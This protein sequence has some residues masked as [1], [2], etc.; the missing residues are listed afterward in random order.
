MRTAHTA[1]GLA[2]LLV[3]ASS[4]FAQAPAPAP[5]A[6]QY[7]SRPLR[8][9]VPFPPGGGTDIGTRIIALLNTEIV[10]I[11]NLPDVK[12]RLLSQGVEPIGNT[13]EQFVA[14]LKS[15]IAK[16]GKLMRESGVKAE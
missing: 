10:R 5:A 9:I 14:V 11:L 13:Q 15:D 8:F 16:Y 4:V 6:G 1:A 7:P 3:A 12:E 2:L